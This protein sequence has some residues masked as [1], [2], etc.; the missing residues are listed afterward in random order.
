MTGWTKDELERIG[1]AEELRLA[2]RRDD[3]SLRKPVIIWVVRLGADLYVRCANGPTGAWFRRAQAAH[4][5]HIEAGG[6]EK[7]VAFLEETDPAIH[8]RIDAAY[9]DKYRRYPQYVAP[10]VTAD[11]KAATLKLVPDKAK[12]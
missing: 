12:A 11:V 8:A 4:T 7:D 10:M 6:T 1:A 9:L 3:G 5:G 2:S